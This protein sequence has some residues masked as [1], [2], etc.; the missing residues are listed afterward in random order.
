MN[1]PFQ[2][3]DIDREAKESDIHVV[4]A[5]P[6]VCLYKGGN[7]QHGF[8]LP[9]ISMH[10]CRGMSFRTA[11]QNPELFELRV[12]LVHP[13]CLDTKEFLTTLVSSPSVMGESSHLFP[14]SASSTEDL[15]L[16]IIEALQV[17]LPL[18]DHILI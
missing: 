3:L 13:T 1:S 12:N 8:T 9:K 14:D 16:W 15:P 6:L 5:H 4:G 11:L 17:F 18:P 10:C 7:H 2:N